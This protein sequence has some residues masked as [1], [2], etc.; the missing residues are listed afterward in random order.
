MW[1]FQ[2][3]VYKYL[4]QGDFYLHLQEENAKLLLLSVV[5]NSV[6]L[7]LV[8]PEISILSN[9]GYPAMLRP[10]SI[11][12]SDLAGYGSQASNTPIAVECISLNVLTYCY[13]ICN[14]LL[15]YKMDK[16]WN[17]AK[18]SPLGLCFEQDSKWKRLKNRQYTLQECCRILEISG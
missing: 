5:N 6:E 15:L 12:I 13:C 2:H 8:L 18:V 11:H 10:S 3:H 16:K 9:L 4:I 7:H 1:W 17:R 14:K